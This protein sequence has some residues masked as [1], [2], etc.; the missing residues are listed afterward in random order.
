MFLISLNLKFETKVLDI[1]YLLMLKLMK[2]PNFKFDKKFVLLQ[3]K[4]LEKQNKYKDAIDFIERRQEFFDDKIERQRIEI[5]LYLQ[6]QQHIH[7]GNVFFNML[8]INSHINQYQDLWP[9][10]KECIRMIIDDFLPKK[11]GFTF[12]PSFELN[13]MKLETKGINFD[14]VTN[15]TSGDDMLTNLVSSIKNLRKNIAI[16][17]SSE[18]IVGIANNMKRTSFMADLEYKFCL[19]LRYP[20]YPTGEKSM[21]FSLIKEYIEAFYDKFDVLGDLRQYLVLLGPIEASALR[22]H[23]REKLDEQE[24]KYQENPDE[25][26][27][28]ALVR[29]R[30]VFFKTNKL[31]GA[32]SNLEKSEKLKLVNTIMQTYLW[33]QAKP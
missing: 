18:R 8:R 9:L 12:N 15:D 24:L 3:I 14:P 28:I 23:V 19:A 20:N 25:L 4:V 16:D 13:L 5:N 26:P 32:F 2:E 1:A 33:S 6:N 7:A 27:G 22:M 11:K 30:F 10:Y 29:W 17:T 21:F 31:L